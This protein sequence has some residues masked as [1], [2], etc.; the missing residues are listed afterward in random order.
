[1]ATKQK[2]NKR[3]LVLLGL[4]VVV[5]GYYVLHTF[6]F[7]SQPARPTGSSGARSTATSSTSGTESRQSEGTREAPVTT[8]EKMQ[9]L[10]DDRSPL[11][12]G[13]LARAGAG[14]A[15]PGTRG[16][17]FDYYKEPPPPPVPPPP[18]PPIRINS[19]NPHYVVAG[20]PRPA[21]MSVSGS[22]FPPDAQ[23]LLN[24]SPRQTKRLN[25]GTL[26]TELSQGEYA[27]QGS[28][29][30]EVKSQSDPVKFY[31]N[32]LNFVIQPSPDP[33]FKYVGRIGELAVLEVGNKEFARMTRGATVQGV[34]RIEAIS[35]AGVDVIHT[36]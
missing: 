23:I 28:F 35:D 6:V 21:K 10:L 34:W 9:V 7:T 8:A 26:S 16:N 2:T 19:V 4:L 13:L 33:P 17:I 29:T 14:P 31:S 5:L 27:R 36:Q 22:A 24:G 3:Q 15:T 18:P 30:V 20:T 25:E 1:M 12:L 11:E 32:T